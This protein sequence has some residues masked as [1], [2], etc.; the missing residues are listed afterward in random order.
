[1]DL[2]LMTG[3]ELKALAYELIVVV[4]RA[5]Q[6]LATVEQELAR[7]VGVDSDVDDDPESPKES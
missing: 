1:M 2:S 6:N 4:G 3:Q 7:R 5:K